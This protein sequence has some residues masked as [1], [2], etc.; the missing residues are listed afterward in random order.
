[1]LDAPPVTMTTRPVRPRSMR[2]GKHGSDDQAVAVG[3][4][5]L[6]PGARARDEAQACRARAREQSGRV[7]ARGNGLRGGNLE[8]DGAAAWPDDVD[9]VARAQ[10]AQ[11]AE[12][13]GLA[14]AIVTGDHRVTGLARRSGTVE[15]ADCV[16]PRGRCH[17]PC[18]VDADRLDHRVDAKARDDEPPSAHPRPYGVEPHA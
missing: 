18:R 15:P 1:R 9:L 16:E 4:R 7:G 13:A 17:G 11:L 3:G 12:Y 2:L 8:R 10:E 14:G 6:E 5:S